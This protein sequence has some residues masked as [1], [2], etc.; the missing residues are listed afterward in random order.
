MYQGMLSLEITSVVCFTHTTVSTIKSIHF[1]SV[2]P[3]VRVQPLTV[4]FIP[5]RGI[6]RSQGEISFRVLTMSLKVSFV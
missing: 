6:I 1:R 4:Y 3:T 5:N 2:N